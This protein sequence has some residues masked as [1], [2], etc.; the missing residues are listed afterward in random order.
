[1][2]K[3][4]KSSTTGATREAARSTVRSSSQ[5]TMGGTRCFMLIV[6]AIAAR[7]TAPEVVISLPFRVLVENE[8]QRCCEDRHSDCGR[9]IQ[10][11]AHE[12]RDRVAAEDACIPERVVVGQRQPDQPALFVAVRN[13]RPGTD[14][15]AVFSE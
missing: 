15:G 8:D 12:A 7:I 13:P 14:V 6:T 5:A 1:G 4:L 11:P 10:E 2:E 3:H 9:E